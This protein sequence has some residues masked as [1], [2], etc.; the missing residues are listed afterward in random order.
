MN[1]LR[2]NDDAMENLSPGTK[3]RKT[4]AIELKEKCAVTL[5]FLGLFF[6]SS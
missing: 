6:L 1:G 3:K 2:R 5:S 4:R